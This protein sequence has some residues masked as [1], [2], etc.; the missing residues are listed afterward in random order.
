VPTQGKAQVNISYTL[1]SNMN[2]NKYQLLIQKQPGT[3]NQKLKVDVDGKNLFN[4]ILDVDKEV[5]TK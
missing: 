3:D 4:G 2:G 5:K 1:P